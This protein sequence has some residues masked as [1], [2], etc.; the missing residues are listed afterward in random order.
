MV[1]DAGMIAGCHACWP[2]TRSLLGQPGT[3]WYLEW[4]VVARQAIHDRR[5]LRSL[6][7]LTASFTDVPEDEP[8]PED[9]PAE[10]ED[11]DSPIA[12]AAE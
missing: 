8:T 1:G 2:T 11:L 7:F 12:V 4:S 5:L 10:S 3:S 6:G 9:G